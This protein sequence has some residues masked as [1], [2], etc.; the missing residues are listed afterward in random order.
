MAC[1]GRI[2]GGESAVCLGKDGLVRTPR[3]H[4]ELDAAD[5]DGDE[6]ADLEELAA[7]I[8]SIAPAE[9]SMFAVRSLAASS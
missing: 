5:T 4:R 6:R 7:A 1:S 2:D 3:R 8:S 9:A